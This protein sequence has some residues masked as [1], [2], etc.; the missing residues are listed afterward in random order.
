MVALVLVF[1]FIGLPALCLW[2]MGFGAVHYVTLVALHALSPRYVRRVYGPLGPPID[3]EV[4][5]EEIAPPDLRNA[6]V[7]ILQTHEAIRRAIQS[8]SEHG[9]HVSTTLSELYGRCTRIVDLVGRVARLGNGLQTYLEGRKP[10][11]LSD[12]AER[13]EACAGRTHDDKAAR[14][15]RQA[16]VARRL[17]HDT[18]CQIE[19]FFERIRARLLLVSSSL[20]SVEALIIKVRTLDLENEALAGDSVS[21]HLADL[22]ADL[23]LL[24]ATMEDA[25]T[26]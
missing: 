19:G 23:Q 7:E 21:E 3:P 14:N 1:A 6:Y 26:E 11:Q 24:E 10:E 22:H 25:L 12:E 8:G 5:V 18:L 20:E 9:R 17:Q 16:A 13:L 4:Q 15:F 2:T